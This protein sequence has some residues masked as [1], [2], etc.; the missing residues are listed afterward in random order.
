M[1]M[2]LT[3][4]DRWSRYCV[5]AA[6]GF[7]A[8]TAQTILFR[9]FLNVFEG[10]ELGIGAFFAS[11]FA[12]VAL[13]A[14]SARA[15]IMAGPALSSA[16]PAL[17]LLYIPAFA[18]QHSAIVRARI[19]TGVEAYELFPLAAMFGASFVVNAP[20]SFLTGFL[21]AMACR[22]AAR[23]TDLPVSRV[24]IAETLGS[25]AGGAAVTGLLAGGA[26]AES[27]FFLAAGMLAFAA[28]V[29]GGS[30]LRRGAFGVI[31][32]AV[33]LGAGLS[34]T[35]DRWAQ[36]NACEYWGRLMP[37]P[38]YHGYFD[39]PEARYLHGAHLGQFMVMAHGG[40]TETLPPEDHAAEIAAIHMA[41]A[42][43][44]K[45]VLVF[46][47]NALGLCAKLRLLPQIEHVTWMAPDPDYPAA[48][49]RVLADIGYEILFPDAMPEMDLR[50]Y[51]L[52]T[53][54]RYDLVILSLP[55]VATLAMNRY[56]TEEFFRIMSGILSDEGVLSVRLAGGENYIGGE[57]ALLGASVLNA[58]KASFASGT[59]KPGEETWV[60]AT[61]GGALT[62]A[63]G[64]LAYRFSAIPGAEQ[65][66]P[67]E[68]LR[69]LFPADRIAAQMTAYEEAA[70]AAGDRLVRNT[71]HRPRATLFS[72]LVS[73]KASEWRQAVRAV[74]MLY[75][76]GLWFFVFPLLLFAV[77][78]MWYLLRARP[79]GTSLSGFESLFLVFS[80]GLA[81]MALNMTLLFGYQARHGSLFLDVG[82]LSALFM[83]GTLIGAFSAVQG[84]GARTQGAA[85]PPLRYAVLLTLHIGVLVGLACAPGDLP[86]AA[87]GGLFVLCGFF[88]GVYFPMAAAA[89]R[90]TGRET[91]A[92]A[93]ALETVDHLGAAFGAVL[94]GMVLLPLFGG[95]AVLGLLAGLV[96][97]NAI[98]ILLP[99]YGRARG[100][101]FDRAVRPAGYT[102]AGVAAWALLVSQVIASA[103]EPH[104]ASPI[105]EGARS[106]AG[107]DASIESLDGALPD[108]T[109]V[110]CARVVGPDGK[111]AGYVFPTEPWAGNVYGY[112]GPIS[113]LV[114]IDPAG[115]LQDYRLL[116]SYETP[117]YMNRV[118]ARRKRLFG[119]NLFDPQ[120]FSGVD[121]ISG[122]TITDVAMRR[123]LS[124]AG[125]GFAADILKS[126]AGETAAGAGDSDHEGPRHRYE[127]ILMASLAFLAVAHRFRPGAATRR[128]FLL[129]T[130]VCAGFWLN[131]QFSMQQVLTLV[132]CNVGGL[133]MT[134]AFFL[135]AV[136]PALIVLFGN[137][138]CGYLCPFGA[139]Q[140]LIGDIGQRL[141]IRAVPKSD[142][143]YG[144][145][146]KFGLL[147]GMLGLFAC[148]RDF[149]L[150]DGDPLVGIFGGSHEGATFIF[151]VAVLV[152]SL[153]FNRFWC[154]N[155][156]P[157]GAFL[158]ILNGI[159]GFGRFLPRRYIGRCDLGVRSPR[160]LDCIDCDRCAI[161]THAPREGGYKLAMAF[162]QCVAIMTIILV[163][164]LAAQFGAAAK[165]AEQGAAPQ[166]V[167]AP[168]ALPKAS[169]TARDVDLDRIRTLTRQGRLSD[170]EALHYAPLPGQNGNP[171]PEGP[172]Q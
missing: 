76:N 127:F 33:A 41:Q 40:I 113:M 146:V 74:P 117:S 57:L 82:V 158:A 108:S 155:L 53:K 130:V 100:D 120:P 9:D 65:L 49:R 58:L 102:L 78:R 10:N 157:T 119:A 25:C 169:G 60:F 15:E 125:R 129:T 52:E 107:T 156:C 136:V 83:L 162:L 38:D 121:G 105:L 95:P 132:T 22:W 3:K 85:P 24:Y 17:A 115:R 42:P 163:W 93:A 72:L 112:M 8:L 86:R 88:T 19:L 137:L 99:A 6:L 134:G 64:A 92:A 47:H 48:L 161:H 63:R 104:E 32:A 71:D 37:R 89:L 12:W 29:S 69:A 31:A 131:L 111:V 164:L 151:G 147:F 11:W 165:P 2:P 87:W 138:Y 55:D 5:V 73:L 14:L 43:E 67:V 103:P 7:F 159:R 143:R 44:A 172:T 154:R 84:A 170:H 142:G 51:A 45:R 140:E 70:T 171:N 4:I 149:S 122:A 36:Y 109:P 94:T 21:F 35:G 118:E 77:L 30:W 75:R 144:R 26:S 20:I 13:G 91:G 23:A 62:Y 54:D 81:S 68:K 124:M 153:F 1:S 150:L 139:L 97:L 106:L 101:W 16:F 128:L 61:N 110:A 27:A 126:E 80:I 96:A 56:C 66:Y 50:R 98:P 141:G 133:R 28:A 167:L 46:G 114:Y 166:A 79:M 145:A 39:T 152:L 168:E 116:R 148:T 135:L 123:T 90:A 18:L 34:G 160:D 59:L